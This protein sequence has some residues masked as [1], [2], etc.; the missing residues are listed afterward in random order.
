M[1]NTPYVDRYWLYT[2]ITRAR[3]LDKVSIFIHSD[4]SVRKLEE[5]K[6]TQYITS[7][8]AGYKGQDKLAGRPITN[9]Y[10]DWNWYEG[11]FEKNKCCFHYQAGFDWKV[12]KDK[13]ITSDLTFDRLDDS[14]CHSQNNLVLSCRYCNCCK[15]QILEKV[16]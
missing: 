2:A 7:K 14:L 5:F 16:A 8:I 10:V 1:P 15:N 13:N 9:D 12:D 3:E 6:A 4:Q 11:E